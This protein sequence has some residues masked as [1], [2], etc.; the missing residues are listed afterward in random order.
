MC[1][2]IC[3]RDRGNEVQ[4]KFILSRLTTPEVIF[5]LAVILH[6]L[7]KSCKRQSSNTLETQKQ[8]QRVQNNSSQWNGWE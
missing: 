3:I 2:G 4:K 7:I 1:G 8:V 5:V 6:S